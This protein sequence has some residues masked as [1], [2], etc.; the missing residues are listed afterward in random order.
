MYRFIIAIIIFM[1]ST[2]VGAHQFTPTYPVFTPS[3][4]QGVSSTKME[5]FNKRKDVSYYEIGVYS[6]SWEPITFATEDKLIY[7]RYLETK[8]VTV[9]LKQEDLT[10]ATYICSESKLRSE[11]VTH[12][13]VS[14]KICSKIK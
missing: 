13:A 6:A 1:V 12:S 7:I 2:L 9:Y 4:M 11:E 5:L 14:S 3:F 8:K 10:K